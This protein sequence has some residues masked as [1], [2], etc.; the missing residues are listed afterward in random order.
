MLGICVMTCM[1]ISTTPLFDQIQFPS[2]NI[3]AIK[4]YGDFNAA[5]E[6]HSGLDFPIQ[7]GEFTRVPYPGSVNYVI[8]LYIPPDH[9]DCI[10]QL[11]TN[12]A[13]DAGWALQH[14][15]LEIDSLYLETEFQDSVV[16]CIPHP[17]HRHVHLSWMVDEEFSSPPA[18]QGYVNP[19]DCL[20]VPTEYDE[21]MF[22]CIF[23]VASPADKKGVYFLRGSDQSSSPTLIFRPVS[24]ALLMQ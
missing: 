16:P 8:N 12:P 14:L 9:L 4:G 3:N 6:F 5:M 20:P 10:L 2:S 21:A 18:Q 22:G 15:D 1:L 24:L 19:F 11:S 13:K 23:H 7:E 17:L